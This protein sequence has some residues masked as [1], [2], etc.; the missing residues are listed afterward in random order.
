MFNMTIKLPVVAFLLTALISSNPLW[1][2]EEPPLITSI[3][4]SGLKR[5]RKSTIRRIIEVQEGDA[6]SAEIEEEIRQNILAAG[7]F[8]TKSLKINSMQEGSNYRIVIFVEDRW[9]LLPIPVFFATD[10]L[11][12][13]GLTLFDAN[14]LGYGLQVFGFFLGGEQF[15]S[16]GLGARFEQT[17]FISTYSDR[18]QK[19]ISTFGNRQTELRSYQSRKFTARFSQGFKLNKYWTISGNMAFQMAEVDTPELENHYAFSIGPGIRYDKQTIVGIFSK[20]LLFMISSNYITPTYVSAQ[21]MGRYGFFLGKNLFQFSIQGA[22][23][24]IPES[25]G[26]EIGNQAGTFTL[27][28][29]VYTRAWSSGRFKVERV[30][31]SPW[32]LSFTASLAYEAGLYSDVKSRITAFHGPG[33]ALSVYFDKVAIPAMSISLYWNL[34]LNKPLFAFNLAGQF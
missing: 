7:I 20:G 10:G 25:F 23:G 16:T 3:E 28:S 9:T 29:S 5:T 34:P 31:F 8:A 21:G 22:W 32:S 6:W 18:K 33:A 14:F 11:W 17:A 15:I 2:L 13:A 12:R 1:S 30:L 27:P 19:D 4:I 24:L 26:Y